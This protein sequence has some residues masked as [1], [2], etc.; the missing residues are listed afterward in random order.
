MESGEESGAT[1]L[2]WRGELAP[3]AGAVDGETWEEFSA[4]YERC[5]SAVL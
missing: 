2:R 4:V 5:F 1:T 3:G